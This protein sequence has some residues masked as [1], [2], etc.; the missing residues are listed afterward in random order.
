ME[1]GGYTGGKFWVRIARK[2]AQ[3]ERSLHGVS[4]WSPKST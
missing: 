2:Y 1:F 4:P 3:I